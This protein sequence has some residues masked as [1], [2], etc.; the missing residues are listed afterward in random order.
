ME[1]FKP[2]EAMKEDLEKIDSI[3]N[4]TSIGNKRDNECIVDII[5]EAEFD[6]QERLEREFKDENVNDADYLRTILLLD[7]NAPKDVYEN[8][9]I[10]KAAD[11]DEEYHH[12][13]G[14]DY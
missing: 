4:S 14:S 13:I 6:F 9:F 8:P 1:K 10:R 12:R 5:H 2:M 7:T 3:I 11:V